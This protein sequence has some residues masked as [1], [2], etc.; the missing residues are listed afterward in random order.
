MRA[1]SVRILMRRLGTVTRNHLEK[2]DLK[3]HPQDPSG[4][5][6]GADET[7]SAAGGQGWDIRLSIWEYY[8]SRHSGTRGEKRQ[9]MTT[10]DHLLDELRYEYGEGRL[11]PFLGSGM[12]RPVCRGW[13]DMIAQLESAVGLRSVP[14]PNEAS[15]RDDF[16]LTRR[17][18]YVLEQLRLEG[19]PDKAAG[20]VRDALLESGPAPP[21]SSTAT[22]ARFDWPLVLTT[23]YDDL[24]VAAVHAKLISRIGGRPRTRVE[25]LCV[26]PV[27]VVGRS[28]SDCHRVLSALR[29]PSALVWA[30]QGFL[31]GQ[32][33]ILIPPAASQNSQ[34]WLDY[35]SAGDGHSG[36][37]S[38]KLKELERQLVVGHAEYRAVAMRS[39]PFRR[40]FAEVCRSRS[41]L[42][43]GSGLRD[44][45]LLDLFSQIAE[46]YGPSSQQHYAVVHRGEVDRGE[47]DVAFLQRYFGIWVLQVD[48]YGE[49]PGLLEKLGSPMSIGVGTIRW[50]CVK[51]TPRRR[52][53]SL[54]VVSSALTAESASSGC[55]VLSGGG[56]EDWPR[57][58]GGMRAFLVGSGFLPERFHNSKS[59]EVGRLFRP[60]EDTI[61]IWVLK[62]GVAQQAH[63]DHA[64]LLVA[65]VRMDP[66]SPPGRL[67][68]PLARPAK[69]AGTGDNAG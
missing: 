60:L 32:G 2:F 11:V 19:G 12:S 24:Y 45:Y 46:L 33:Q 56:S 41:F 44:R 3:A 40:A 59:E 9:I 39:E 29:W 14:E 63:N 68:R 69:Q 52:L 27:E 61:F 35:I 16:E 43:L 57:L 37:S 25:E 8:L 64:A 20:A 55:V 34:L 23:N 49:I 67:L 66:A 47:V 48:D 58:S 62:Q 10:P 7:R 4:R 50:S 26:P 28:Q 18:A 38:E 5:P 65:R 6:R 53:P 30:L 17:A 51:Q 15:R 54:S 31:P 42:F 22:L 13:A 36:F 21:P 1:L